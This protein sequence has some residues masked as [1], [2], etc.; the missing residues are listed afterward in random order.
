MYIRCTYFFLQNCTERLFG[1][2]SERRE[3]RCGFLIAVRLVMLQCA[4]RGEHF[5]KIGRP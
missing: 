5:G 2:F 4:K 3:Q 1:S